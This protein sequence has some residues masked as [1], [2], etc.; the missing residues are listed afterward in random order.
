MK[1]KNRKLVVFNSNDG[2]DYQFYALV[3]ALSTPIQN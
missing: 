3:H 1:I 2:A